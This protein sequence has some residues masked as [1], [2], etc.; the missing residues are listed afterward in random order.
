MGDRNYSE[1]LKLRNEKYQAKQIMSIFHGIVKNKAEVG[2]FYQNHFKVRNRVRNNPY[3]L[4]A[5]IEHA[6][7]KPVIKIT[8]NIDSEWEKYLPHLD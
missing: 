3:Q 6:L 4:I 5:D 7:Q 2:K 8:T 1:E